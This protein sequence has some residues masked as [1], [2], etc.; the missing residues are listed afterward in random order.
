MPARIGYNDVMTI[1][2]WLVKQEPETYSWSTFVKDSRAAWTGIRNFQARNFLRAMR[3]KDRVLYYHTGSNREVVGLAHVVREA[4]PDPTA[5][6]GAWVC[7]DLE[8]IRTLRRPVPLSSIQ[9]DRILQ[10][11]LFVRQPRL[12]VSPVDREQFERVLTLSQSKRRPGASTD[13]AH[14]GLDG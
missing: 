2:Y 13:S 12:S 8:P 10:Q 5:D 7:V 6:D 4:Y 11:M 14:P 9:G 3:R 1:G